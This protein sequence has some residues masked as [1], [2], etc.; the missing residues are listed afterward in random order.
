MLK[1]RLLLVDDHELLRQGL[2]SLIDS[3]RDLEVVGQAGDGLAALIADGVPMEKL[4][5]IDANRAFKKLEQLKPHVLVWWNSGAQ[6]VQI[7]QDG[8]VDMVTAP[9]L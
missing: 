5:P 7:L 8:E 9:A 2:A 3:Q 4:Y 6:S 1:A